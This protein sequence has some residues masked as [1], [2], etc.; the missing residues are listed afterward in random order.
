MAE[1]K[2]GNKIHLLTKLK[3]SVLSK[4]VS[5]ASLN[6]LPSPLK[7]DLNK[8]LNQ[9]LIFYQQSLIKGALKVISPEKL[10][11]L[12]NPQTPQINK[13]ETVLIVIPHNKIKYVFQTIL[14]NS[15]SEGFILK[16]IK[17]RHDKRLVLNTS[18]PV[19]ISFVS[20]NLFL[21]FL[22]KDYFLVR[23][24]NFS[25]D[26]PSLKNLEFYDIIFDENNNVDKDFQSLIH[27]SHLK[28]ELID[29]S[30]G[31]ICIK[32]GS[33]LQIPENTH[34]IYT[35]FEISVEE[36]EL[37][38]GLL[39]HL[40]NARIEGNSSILHLMFLIG[41]KPEV[42]NKIEEIIKPLIS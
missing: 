33:I 23:N 36:S 26:D 4:N 38:F 29:I 2:S 3:T 42:W 28:G 40:R 34:L 24:S 31:G 39:S 15:T 32:I 1:T 12:K 10:L 9:A 35:K 17:P 18:V 14:E 22:Q 21:N 13:G 37:K 19:F 7:K 5:L 27:K 11:L 8:T 6:Y 16:I 20:Y 25:L 41:F 30:S